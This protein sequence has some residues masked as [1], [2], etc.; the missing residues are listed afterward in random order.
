RSARRQFHTIKGSGRMV[1]LNEL[2]EL[3]YDVEQIQN[4]LLEE[5]RDVTPAMLELLDVAEADFRMWVGALQD[6]GD[7][8]AD[9]RALFAA[10][11]R[12]AAELPSEFEVESAAAPEPGAAGAV[13]VAEAAAVAPLPEEDVETIEFE[14]APEFPTAYEEAAE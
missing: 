9:P 10:I 2:G 11:A 3:A 7:V 12:V 8:Y 4:R 6:T 1:G 5:D 13:A 14:P